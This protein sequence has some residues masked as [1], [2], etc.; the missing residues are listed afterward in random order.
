M[1]NFMNPYPKAYEEESPIKIKA[2][3]PTK[4]T[5]EQERSGER[6]VGKAI[7]NKAQIYNRIQIC[8]RIQF[9]SRIAS[10]DKEK[11]GPRPF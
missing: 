7:Y 6:S 1:P 8:R 3:K 4:K 11:L 2:Q 9:F 5:K 10:A